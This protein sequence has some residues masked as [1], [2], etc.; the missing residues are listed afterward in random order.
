MCHNTICLL[1]KSLFSKNWESI[2]LTWEVQVGLKAILVSDLFFIAKARREN[3]ERA[4][5]FDGASLIISKKVRSLNI[6][7][8]KYKRLLSN[9]GSKLSFHFEFIFIRNYI[10]GVKYFI[11]WSALALKILCYLID[12]FRM[13]CRNLRKFLNTHLALVLHFHVDSWIQRPFCKSLE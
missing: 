9:F 10:I 11:G 6:W 13:H 3:S 5:K 2:K 8:C 12:S 1:S 4:L 7:L